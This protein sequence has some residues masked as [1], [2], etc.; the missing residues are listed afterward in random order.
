MSIRVFIVDDHRVFREGL[1]AV[2]AD[3]SGIEVVGEA[4]DGQTAVTGVTTLRPDVVLMDLGLPIVGG[5]ESLGGQVSVGGRVSLGAPA[6][7]RGT[8]RPAG[9]SS[10]GGLLRPAGP[11]SLGGI[12]ATARIRSLAPECRVLV[13]SMLD[14]RSA[15]QA[16][17]RAGARGYLVKTAGL[18]D[19]VRGIQAT[20]AGQF[21]FDEAAGLHV[22]GMRG[23]DVDR[24]AESGP[25][26]TG[27]E[28]Q[29]LRLLAE[30]STTGQIAER[31]GIST[32]TVRN[33]LSALYLKLGVTDRTQ[34]AM[35]AREL[36]G[37]AD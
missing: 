30:G 3:H 32:K 14:D 17:V 33:H 7:M 1:R 16:A 2:L 9:P 25:A 29:V 20:A 6:S 8:V 27:R 28:R 19:I 35:R 31:L 23:D 11:V 5:P 21:L 4:A 36:T 12:E 26:L 15:V 37:G 18:A 24:P 13:L 10:L 34:A 22:F